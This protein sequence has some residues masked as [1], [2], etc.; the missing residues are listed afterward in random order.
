MPD[1]AVFAELTDDIVRHATAGI[2]PGLE[3]TYRILALL[4]DPQKRF[5]SIHVLGTNGKGSTAAALDSIL[6]TA[7]ARTALI[8][9]PH[10]ISLK[11][12]LMIGG[13]YL[14]ADVW[15][16]AYERTRV[17]ASNDPELS[18]TPPTFFEYLIAMSFLM[19][20]EAGVDIAVVEAGMGG[21]YDATSTCERLATV[22][23]PI[24]MD[25]TEYLG[26][27][28]EEIASEKFAAVRQGSPAFFAG[29]TD[30]LDHLF[31]E[32]CSHIGA[33]SYILD[34][35]ERAEDITFDLSGTSFALSGHHL[36]TSL[37]GRHQAENI[38]R[39]V[40][41][42]RTMHELGLFDSSIKLSYKIISSAIDGIVWPGRFEIIKGEG[43]PDIILDGA[44][45]PHGMSALVETVE[46]MVSSC[47]LDIGAV[48]FA[49]M[50][51][52]DISPTLDIL[53]RL[54]RGV[55]CTAPDTPRAMPPAEL[56]DIARERGLE[57]GGAFDDPLDA[58]HAAE[59]V[60]C[61][62]QHVLCCG[63]L[64]LIGHLRA[65]LV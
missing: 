44:H 65:E 53:K 4:G 2:R 22:I 11:E 9:S 1:R 3:R 28:L 31:C 54:H 43:N 24:G 12:R 21:R 47:S 20:S 25:H 7:G 17:A 51:D 55:Y 61:D 38:S 50:K 26:D 45:N 48:V 23:A 14:G 52:K 40:I 32:T 39:A 35:I 34:K 57:V 6:R 36:H 58:L 60:C 33:H 63:S 5:K 42:V 15:R 27:T 49:V 13:R 37:I 64:Y 46:A 62:G 56:A 16:D 30:S 59:R 19:A 29:G 10:L 18:S 8:T 41:A